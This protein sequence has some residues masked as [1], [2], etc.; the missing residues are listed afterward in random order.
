M[1]EVQIA[2]DPGTWVPLDGSTVAPS[3]LAAAAVVAR[4]TSTDS[5]A[6]EEDERF[7]LL[8]DPIEPPVV[9]N[10]MAQPLEV[11][12]AR[13]GAEAL[14]PDAPLESLEDVEL[15]SGVSAC[16]HLVFP[17]AGALV[18]GVP[19]ATTVLA[20]LH[21]VRVLQGPG[22]GWL[23]VATVVTPRLNDL[24]GIAEEVETLFAQAVIT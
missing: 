10:V 4:L 7:L 11:K 1:P 22:T 13:A 6:S 24:A 17:Q 2:Y 23:L 5:A 3:G 19:S 20:A 18:P 16:R 12:S 8:A 15:A 14:F 9:L 21:Y